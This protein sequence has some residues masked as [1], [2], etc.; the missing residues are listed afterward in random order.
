MPPAD[1]TYAVLDTNALLLPFTDGTDLQEEL[2]RLV[3]SHRLVVPSSI[4]QELQGLAEGTDAAIARHARAALLFMERCR[5]EPTGLPGDDGILEV[6]RRLSAVVVSN[7]K[8]V[9]SEARRSGLKAIGSRGKGRLDF[10]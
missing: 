2:L 9:R 10:L 4:H 3:G 7:D 1:G 6:A 5:V 8:N